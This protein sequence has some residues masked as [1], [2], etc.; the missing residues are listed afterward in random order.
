MEALIA[1]RVAALH[2]RSG[3]PMVALKAFERMLVTFGEMTDIASVS[4]WRASLAVLLAKLGHHEAAATLHGTFADAI[5]TAGVV[6][7]H[8]EAIE[9]VRSK[10][11]D[12]AF[13]TAA[14]RGAKMSLREASN[15]AIEQVRLG[16]EGFD[17]H[18]SGGAVH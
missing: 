16:L 1:P 14:T 18:L 10:L 2:A 8:A 4:A 5:D 11:G 17:E 6:P 3:E 13:S 7:E 9:G 15:Y 12:A